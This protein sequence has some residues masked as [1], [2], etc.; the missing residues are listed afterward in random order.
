MEVA[1][2]LDTEAVQTATELGMTAV[3]AGTVGTREPFV[4]GLVDLLVERAA[5]ARGEAVA[6]ATVGDL[7]AF[8]SV[9]APGCCLRR[10]GEPSGVPALCSTDVH[11]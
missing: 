3:R 8:R 4:R 7:P 10:D 5:I 6:E 1:Y 11:S 2:D 9:C